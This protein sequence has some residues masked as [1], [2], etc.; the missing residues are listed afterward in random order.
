MVEMIP[1]QEAQLADLAKNSK[2][3][4]DHARAMMDASLAA[5]NNTDHDIIPREGDSEEQ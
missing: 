5:L 2:T 3:N 1:E 4:P